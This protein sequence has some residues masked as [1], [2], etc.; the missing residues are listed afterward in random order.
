MVGAGLGGAQDPLDEILLAQGGMEDEL[1][2]LAGQVAALDKIVKK[3]WT[4]TPNPALRW[5]DLDEDARAATVARLRDWAARVYEP[6]FGHLGRLPECWP[7]HPLIVIMLD[8]LSD[9]RDVL[10]AGPLR[11]YTQ[12]N[13]LAEFFCRYLPQVADMFRRETQSCPHQAAGFNAG[14]AAFGQ[15]PSL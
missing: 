12:L 11:T 15:P 3:A 1:H 5:E 9:L 2:R 7:E 4:V 6:Q 13:G 14:A 8:W 10:T